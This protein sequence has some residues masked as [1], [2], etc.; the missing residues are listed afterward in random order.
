MHAKSTCAWSS[1]KSFINWKKDYNLQHAEDNH[2]QVKWRFISSNLINLLHLA[3]EVKLIIFSTLKILSFRSHGRLLSLACWRLQYIFKLIKRCAAWLGASGFNMHIQAFKTVW[4]HIYHP[5]ALFKAWH[6]WSGASRLSK[7]EMDSAL[8]YSFHSCVTFP[9]P[10][11]HC[12][13][14]PLWVCIMEELSK[15]RI[16]IISGKMLFP[17]LYIPS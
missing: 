6:S 2:L 10:T 15:C 11:F 12:L 3:K 1:S 17:L 13:W 4:W 14:W 16:P 7:L 8:P 9:A 5:E